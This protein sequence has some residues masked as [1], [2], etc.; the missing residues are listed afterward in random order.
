MYQTRFLQAADT[1]LKLYSSFIRPHLEYAAPVWDP[2]LNKD[3][4]LLVEDVQKFGLRVCTKSWNKDYGELLAPSRLPT[5]Q[6]RHQ[7][8]KLC[9][10]YKIDHSSLA[11]AP[12]QTIEF[13]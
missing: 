6:A 11:D 1:V 7:Q 13:M 10:L 12:I 8:A 5:L 3:I 9:Q 4:D 2:F